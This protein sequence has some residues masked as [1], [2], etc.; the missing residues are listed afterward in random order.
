MVIIALYTLVVKCKIASV[1]YHQQEWYVH[2]SLILSLKLLLLLHHF[3]PYQKSL[4]WHVY[5]WWLSSVDVV[6]VWMILYKGGIIVFHL[7]AKIITNLGICF[8]FISAARMHGGWINGILTLF[9]TS[10]GL[11]NAQVSLHCSQGTGGPYF[12]TEL[13]H[14]E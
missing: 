10:S 13:L 7:P 12:F 2:Q 8:G 6:I 3:S 4:H 14:L 5:A 9:K 1:D 11:L